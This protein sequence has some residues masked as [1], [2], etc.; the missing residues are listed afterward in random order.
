MKPNKNILRAD[1]KASPLNLLLVWLLLILCPILLFLTLGERIIEEGEE[2]YSKELKAELNSELLAFRQDLTHNSYL[3]N[4]LEKCI[5]ILEQSPD[6]ANL[7]KNL[8]AI[9]ERELQ[10]KPVLCLSYSAPTKKASVHISQKYRGKI[11]YVSNLIAREA[12]EF[13]GLISVLDRGIQLKEPAGYKRAAIYL[14]KLLKLNAELDINPNEAASFLSGIPELNRVLLCYLP[15]RAKNDLSHSGILLVI[16]EADISVESIVRFARGRVQHSKTTRSIAKGHGQPIRLNHIT[17]NEKNFSTDPKSGAFYL[18]GFLSEQLILKLATGEGFY[19]ANIYKMRENWPM[20]RVSVLPEHLSSP[21]KRLFEQ[22]RRPILIVFLLASVL[23]LRIRLFGLGSRLGLAVVLLLSLVFAALIPFSVL[24]M[25]LFY[26]QGH[27]ATMEKI[28]TNLACRT[29]MEQ[30]EQSVLGF[31]SNMETTIPVVCEG[32]VAEDVVTTINNFKANIKAINARVIVHNQ[33]EENYSIVYNQGNPQEVLVYNERNLAVDDE[34]RVLEFQPRLDNGEID[35]RLDDAER[36]MLKLI[37]NVLNNSL[38]P[39][40][41]H[42]IL[43]ATTFKA[44]FFATLKSY[45]MFFDALS[46]LNT[47]NDGPLNRIFTIMPSF[48]SSEHNKF[49][50]KLNSLSTFFFRIDQVLQEYIKKHPRALAFA[51]K[52]Y[53]YKACLIP[54]NRPDEKPTSSAYLCHPSFNKKSVNDIVNTTTFTMSGAIIEEKDSILMSRLIKKLNTI[55]VLRVSKQ[56]NSTGAQEY[57]YLLAGLLYFSLVLFVI[58]LYFWRVFINPIKLLTAGAQEVAKENYKD[59]I[60]IQ[61]KDEFGELTQ[62]FNKMTQGLMV[63]E[64]MSSYVA[65]DVLDEIGK[66]DQAL[67]PGGEK[68]TVSI[69]FCSIEGFNQLRAELSENSFN[70]LLND[71]IDLVDNVSS[72]HNGQIDKL[73][74]DTLMIV[75]RQKDKSSN[76][77]VLNCANAVLEM[78]ESFLSLAHKN[79]RLIF[80]IATGEVI[81]GKIG[82]HTGKLDFT[83]IGN[84][85]NLASRLK[86]QA[87]QA[88]NTGILLCPQ[89]I[90][91]LKGAAILTFIK[92][93]PIKGRSRAFS[94][95]ELTGLRN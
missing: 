66:T 40:Q 93:V 8:L 17:D 74:G 81:S 42:E 88:T 87:H 46:R 39:L 45:S 75:F 20:L 18:D 6:S 70:E 53:I 15:L 32:L 82:S 95:Y 38:K 94:L 31:V 71:F 90:R 9:M 50:I 80:G 41:M 61:N 54:L 72:K 68:I 10:L 22:S 16:K 83:V 5:R 37:L 36:D 86:G 30:L 29:A 23:L 35:N 4:Q 34:L 12:L 44:P 26:H 67:L 78:Q 84:S 7:E 77:F 27:R 47:A 13:K 51:D 91:Q 14:K 43:S 49:H 69:V 28:E 64:L 19:P 56:V 76:Q 2:R 57:R 52:D 89:T 92:R 58:L 79:L 3:D 73:I 21:M 1:L 24:G 11:G 48:T 25:V 63:K 33:E 85:A 65:T 60:Q 55:A 59:R 62:A